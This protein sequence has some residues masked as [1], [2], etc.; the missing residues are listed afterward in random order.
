MGEDG[1]EGEAE[2]RDVVGGLEGVFEVALVGGV[3]FGVLDEEEDAEW[4]RRG[5]FRGAVVSVG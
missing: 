3:A 1:G 4:E 5:G 2:G